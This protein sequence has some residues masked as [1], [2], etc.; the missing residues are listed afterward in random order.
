LPSP[1][2]ASYWWKQ[3]IVSW[4]SI[5]SSKFIRDSYNNSYGVELHIVFGIETPT[6]R[7]VNGS[8]AYTFLLL[9]VCTNHFSTLLPAHLCCLQN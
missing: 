3:L 4:T 5:I 8:P 7:Y 2:A 6:V 1:L 9:L